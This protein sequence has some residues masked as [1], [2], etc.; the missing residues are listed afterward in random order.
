MTIKGQATVADLIGSACSSAPAGTAGLSRC[1]Q[2]AT[3]CPQPS[4]KTST[5][6][7]CGSGPTASRSTPWAPGQARRHPGAGERHFGQVAADDQNARQAS[8][9]GG[10]RPEH[11]PRGA[12]FAGLAGGIPHDCGSLFSLS[13]RGHKMP[14]WNA[15]MPPNVPPE[16]TGLCRT[17]P[18]VTELL[19]CGFHRGKRKRPHVFGTMRPY[20][21]CPGPESNRHALRR[22]ILSPLRLPIS[23]PGR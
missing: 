3:R 15:T 20:L 16:L 10:I 21:W 17:S 11:T 19:T 2:F 4:G 5:W 23:P 22:G 7:A 14:P 6:C 9:P 1:P 12:R 8:T 13:G 18:N